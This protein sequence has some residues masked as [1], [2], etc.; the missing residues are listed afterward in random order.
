MATVIKT[1]GNTL[2][3]IDATV[4]KEEEYSGSVT[5]HPIQDGSQIT[6][7]V[8]LNNPR[9]TLS[10]VVSDYDFQIGR[11]QLS[12][13]MGG[14][15]VTLSE[16]DVPVFVTYSTPSPL[17]KIIPEALSNL[18]APPTPEVVVKEFERPFSGLSSKD[19]LIAA[20]DARDFLTIATF[21][22]DG[23]LYEIFRDYIITGLSF[24]ESA[25]TGEALEVSL[26]FEKIVK[27]VIS[28]AV[29]PEAVS[30]GLEA[31]IA[32]RTSKGD[33]AGATTTTDGAG[34]AD[35]KEDPTQ[36]T[37]ILSDMTGGLRQTISDGF[38]RLSQ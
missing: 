18:V 21:G 14:V 5:S 35:A 20:R 19:A 24:K 10:G 30:L 13:D 34:K 23:I 3:W 36:V 8:I 37:S 17:S 28:T 11:T 9:L 26:S 22:T 32:G 25:D 2:I 4:S 7:H 31:K 6:D 1:K 38:T 27:V 12:S 16:V 15:P 29:V 33:A